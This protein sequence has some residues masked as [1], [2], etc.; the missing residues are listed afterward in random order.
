MKM[1]ICTLS[2]KVYK[3]MRSHN[4]FFRYRQQKEETRPKRGQD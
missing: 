2:V 1:E 3:Y 4:F